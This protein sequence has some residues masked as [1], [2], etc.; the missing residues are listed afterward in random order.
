MRTRAQAEQIKRDLRSAGYTQ[1]R[2]AHSTRPHVTQQAVSEVIYGRKRS[3]R[4]ERVLERIL[5]YALPATVEP[6]E[7]DTTR[8]AAMAAERAEPPQPPVSGGAATGRVL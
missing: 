8:D 3:R 5:G 6:E 2:V 4:I 1:T 7:L